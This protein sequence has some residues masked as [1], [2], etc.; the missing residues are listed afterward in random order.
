MRY[1]LMCVCVPHGEGRGTE[2]GRQDIFLRRSAEAQRL[3]M[4]SLGPTFDIT[5]SETPLI[6]D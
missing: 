1:D 6:V 4:L 5:S 3:T 2:S